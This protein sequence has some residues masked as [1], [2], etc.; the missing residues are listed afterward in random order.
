MGLNSS[1]VLL[2]MVCEE[3]GGRVDLAKAYY[4]AITTSMM[5]HFKGNDAIASMELCNDFMFLGTEAISLSRVG[6]DSWCANSPGDPD[7]T[8]WL[9]GYHMVHGAYN[10]LWLGNYMYPN[11]DMFQ[12]T[13]H[14]GAFNCQ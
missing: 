3:Y 11:W 9:Q 10:S 4:K 13:N 1:I 7:D 8:F 5:K 12:S 2:E 6:N 14:C